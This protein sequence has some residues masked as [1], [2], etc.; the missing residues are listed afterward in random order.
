LN[1]NSNTLLIIFKP[2]QGELVRELQI[3]PYNHANLNSQSLRTSQIGIFGNFSDFS[4]QVSTPNKFR[5]NL[6][7]V[8]LPGFL[9]QI[10]FQILT[11]F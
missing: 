9:I 10:L 11:Y 1:S 7:A 3:S 2:S 5:S 8:L 6:K 4:K